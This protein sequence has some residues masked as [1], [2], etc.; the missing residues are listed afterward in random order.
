MSECL[1]GLGTGLEPTA[2]EAAVARP[3]RVAPLGPADEQHHLDHHLTNEVRLAGHTVARRRCGQRGEVVVA[4]AEPEGDLPALGADPEGPVRVVGVLEPE[5]AVA[6]LG[7]LPQ[8]RDVAG[9]HPRQEAHGLRHALIQHGRVDGHDSHL[10][11]SRQQLPVV[12]RSPDLA[13]TPT[14]GLLSRAAPETC[15]QL[16]WPRPETRPQRRPSWGPTPRVA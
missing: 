1:T 4:L 11:P 12:A 5:L 6:A 14:E 8:P 13:T 16:S 15:G 2:P 10:P 7:L 3:S 9:Q